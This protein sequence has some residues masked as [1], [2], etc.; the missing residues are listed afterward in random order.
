MQCG[1]WWEKRGE[2]S[3]GQ[4]TGGRCLPRRK[5]EEGG[6]SGLGKFQVSGILPGPSIPFQLWSRWGTQAEDF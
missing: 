1:A 6:G 4:S 2:H 5:E 3:A